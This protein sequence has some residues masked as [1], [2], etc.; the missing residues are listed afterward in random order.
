MAPPGARRGVDPAREVPVSVPVPDS[1]TRPSF[2]RGP[3]R[4]C[5]V[6]LERATR[7]PPLARHRVDDGDLRVLRPSERP[8]VRPARP[9]P[10]RR[11]GPRSLRGAGRR[12]VLRP[13]ADRLPDH[14]EPDRGR[15]DS[16][17]VHPTP[18]RRMGEGGRPARD[19]GD[20]P[21]GGV[22][23]DGADPR[24]R[25]VHV[26][27]SDSR[28][29]RIELPRG[30]LILQLHPPSGPR[31]R[32]RIRH[33]R[34]DPD[35]DRAVGHPA[36]PGGCCKST[37]NKVNF[38]GANLFPAMVLPEF[39]ARRALLSEDEV[40]ARLREGPGWSRAGKVIERTWPFHDFSQAL[41]FINKLGA[42]TE[43]MNHDPDIANSWATVRLTL[44]T[45]D[46]G[47]LT[48]LDFDLANKIN[49]L[50]AQ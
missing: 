23:A 29:C 15:P 7:R 42:L 1:G 47:G 38:R 9:F 2:V 48:N 18:R 30:I 14:A 21:H 4:E 31:H 12:S 6:H 19:V 17:G 39:V 46:K 34:A 28:G 13:R 24:R 20:V 49:S 5:E 43:A 41:A 50:Q 27:D 44:T 10:V 45:H 36:G 26:R 32:L 33:H 35:R 22:R 37:L 3:T 25:A 8:H 11:P 40:A 16:P